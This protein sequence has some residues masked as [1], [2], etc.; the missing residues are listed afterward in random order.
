[1]INQIRAVPHTWGSVAFQKTNQSQ[2]HQVVFSANYVAWL[3]LR[4]LVLST[5]KVHGFGGGGGRIFQKSGS[6]P[7]IM[8]SC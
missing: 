6:S 8:V 2:E 7:F 4:L 3:A 1:M 5:L